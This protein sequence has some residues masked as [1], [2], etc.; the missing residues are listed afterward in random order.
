V[1]QRLTREGDVVLDLAGAPLFHVLTG[2]FGPG[3]SDVV[4]PGIFITP[5][6]EHRFVEGLA[7]RPPR[8]I[9]WPRFDFDGMPER[10]ITVAAPQL[11]AWVRANYRTEIVIEPYEILVP[12]EGAE[13]PR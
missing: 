4:T 1:I 6:E 7:L 10:S 9:I 3:T 11:A 2:R 8:A 5:D 12:G 13:S